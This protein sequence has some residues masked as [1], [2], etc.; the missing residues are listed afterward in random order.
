MFHSSE[1]EDP[2][3]REHLDDMYFNPDC[4]SFDSKDYT[5]RLICQFVLRIIQ[6]E[7]RVVDIRKCFFNLMAK[8]DVS[9]LQ[10]FQRLDKANKSYVTY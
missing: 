9:H 8:R 4:T 5:K 2:M 3:F 10:L 7:E 1:V 6:N